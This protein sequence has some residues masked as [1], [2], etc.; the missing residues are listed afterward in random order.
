[1]GEARM[2][3]DIGKQFGNYRLTHLLGEGGFS[4]VYLGEHILLESQAAIKVLHET[5]SDKHKADF[6]MEARRLARLRHP[7]IVRILEFGMEEDIPF[8]VMEYA[9]NGS[10]RTRYPKGSKI[11]IETIVIYVK[12]VAEALSY[13]HEQKLVHRD[14]K[15]E[16]MLLGSNEEVLLSDFGIAAVAHNTGSIVIQGQAGTAPY[17]APEQ[18]MEM[19]RPASDQ[20]ALGVT[21]YEWLSGIRPFQGSTLSILHQ[22]VY[23]PPTPLHEQGC[24]LSSAIEDVIMQA[25]AKDPK[26]RFA[27]VRS[28]A[29]A[30]ERAVLLFKESISTQSFKVSPSF[31]A[32]TASLNLSSALPSVNASFRPPE[33][34][35]EPKSSH[36]EVPLA[37]PLS[38]SNSSAY[39]SYSAPTPSF[40]NTEQAFPIDFSQQRI[41]SRALGY[42]QQLPIPQN[43]KKSA[44]GRDQIKVGRNTVLI[45]LVLLLILSG[46]GSYI[47]V[48]SFSNGKNNS[49]QTSRNDSNFGIS[50]PTS[51]PTSTPAIQPVPLG[52]PVINQALYQERADGSTLYTLSAYAVDRSADLG[53]GN[54]IHVS[55]ITCRLWLTKDGKVNAN[56]P[57]DR[58]RSVNTLQAPFPKEVSDALNFSSDTSQVQSTD[59][60]GQA[61]W[62]Y[63]LPSSLGSGAYYLVVLMDWNG[64]YYNYSW[65]MITII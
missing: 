2:G 57:S 12:Q 50:T 17:M 39:T 36:N 1:M 65:I 46:V 11:P 43:E 26:Q 62:K 5:V 35:D 4:K 9:P 3:D 32:D 45:M 15:P 34:I 44:E 41:D 40:L 23:A 27:D 6:L 24:E 14:V 7:H 56:M 13:L 63:T 25:L 31:S 29:D 52:Y 48:Q 22:H 53:H 54:P 37:R 61:T 33:I 42:S 38:F 10:L 19:P 20:Y 58:L 64:V 55:G 28:F 21:I 8:L 51:T 60:D 47:L 30:L 18:I 59:S 49:S 16:N